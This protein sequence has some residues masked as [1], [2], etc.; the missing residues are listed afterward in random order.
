[1]H[2]CPQFSHGFQPSICIWSYKKIMQKTGRKHTKPW[3]WTR[4]QHRTRRSQM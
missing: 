1:V 2:A 3:E 4:S